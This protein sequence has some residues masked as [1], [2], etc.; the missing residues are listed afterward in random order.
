MN[1]P[2]LLLLIAFALIGLSVLTLIFT[3]IRYNRQYVSVVGRVRS[4]EKSRDSDNV[5]EFQARYTFRDQT[6]REFEGRS[7]GRAHFSPYHEGQDIRVLY[8]LDNPEKS[9]VDSFRDKYA[10]PLFLFALGAGL[11]LVVRISAR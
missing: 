5:A 4:V 8:S 2:N 9:T 6:G 7:V 11:I 10:W 3:M 1:I